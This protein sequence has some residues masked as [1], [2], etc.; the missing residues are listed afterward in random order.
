MNMYRKE[1]HR[2]ALR[3]RHTRQVGVE[4]QVGL[5]FSSAGITLF[6]PRDTA[7][8]LIRTGAFKRALAYRSLPK[9]Q[10]Q[11]PKQSSEMATTAKGSAGSHTGTLRISKGLKTAATTAAIATPRKIPKARFGCLRQAT[12][13]K[14]RNRR[15]Q[16]ICSNVAMIEKIQQ[17]AAAP[18]RTG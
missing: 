16:A 3:R 6:P 7:E 18:Q 13:H 4:A 10:A 5:W 11:M 8:F 2:A 17:K 15:R 9:N 1:R 14:T 12:P